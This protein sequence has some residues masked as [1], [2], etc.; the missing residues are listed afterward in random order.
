MYQ[1]LSAKSAVYETMTAELVAE[2][3]WH[4]FID[5]REYFSHTGPELPDSQ[6][7]ALRDCLRS[8]SLK[9]TINCP[10]ALLLGRTGSSAAVVSHSGMSAG[11]GSRTTSRGGTG[12][13]T[14]T[15]S[16]LTGVRTAPAQ[17]GGKWTNPT[18]IPEIV[19][20][21]SDFRTAEAGGGHA[22]SDA[23]PKAPDV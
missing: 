23:L 11:G 17:I 20:I 12:G 3:L 4:V 7:F 21:M 6:L 8:C 10:V 22:Y 15:M 16:T 9:T 13:S 19:S 1:I 14:S 2:T 5:A 18:P